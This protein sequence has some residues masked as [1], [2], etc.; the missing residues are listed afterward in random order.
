MILCLGLLFLTTAWGQAVTSGVLLGTI[1]DAS[2]ALVPGARVTVTNTATGQERQTETS[3]NGDFRF[4]LLPPGF[5]RFHV[6]KPGFQTLASDPVEVQ[7]GVERRVDFAI[8]VG[9]T[10]TTVEVQATATDINTTNAERGEVVE[11]KRI[12]ELPLNFREFTQLALLSPGAVLDVRQRIFALKT[13]ISVNGLRAQNGNVVI[14]GID[15][16]ETH[17][18]GASMSFYNLDSVA[19]FKLT[20]SNYSAE[21]RGSSYNVR[22]VTKSN[23][24]VARDSV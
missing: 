14:D 21:L 15:S 23:K 16:N 22:A 9:E 8:K 2:G 1:T 12:T 19:E 24:P 11:G 13:N 17:W 7:V 10:T 4:S 3:S 6:E 5:Y 20:T 18:G